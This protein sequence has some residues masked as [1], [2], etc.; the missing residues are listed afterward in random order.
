MAGD[1]RTFAEG[2]AAIARRFGVPVRPAP[3]PS[4]SSRVRADGV[5]VQAH[6]AENGYPADPAALRRLHPDLTSFEA[7]LAGERLAE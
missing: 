4:P 6:F 1:E 2:K 5:R 3:T 7:W